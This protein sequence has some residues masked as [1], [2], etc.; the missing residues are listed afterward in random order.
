[1]FQNF[2]HCWIRKFH[3]RPTL[4]LSS[5]SPRL[6]YLLL[7]LFGP[8]CPYSAHCISGSHKS[9]VLSRSRY[10]CSQFLCTNCHLN[11]DPNKCCSKL[12]SINCECNPIIVCA[13][14]KVSCSFLVYFFF[15]SNQRC[16][17]VD[18]S[19]FELEEDE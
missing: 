5:L 1:M 9:A 19:P 10:Q 7:R 15:F 3:P 14:K 4:A 17:V 16:L 18:F 13:H 2:H 11:P 6:L 8:L 12:N